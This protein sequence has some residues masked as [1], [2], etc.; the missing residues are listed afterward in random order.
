MPYDCPTCG[1]L[2]PGVHS[3][4]CSLAGLPVWPGYRPFDWQPAFDWIEQRLDAF[5]TQWPG[6][7]LLVD[8]ESLEY[9]V[10][11]TDQEAF[12]P[13][14]PPFGPTPATGRRLVC[15]QL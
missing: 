6:Q 8:A 2:E 7:V 3:A 13:K 14:N 4:N 10:F 12:D 15:Q 1:A 9:K 11:A 5:K